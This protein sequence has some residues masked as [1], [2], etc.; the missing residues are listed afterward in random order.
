MLDHSAQH[1]LAAPRDYQLV[2]QKAAWPVQP[3][4]GVELVE[5]E[6]VRADGLDVPPLPAGPV[7]KAKLVERTNGARCKQPRG[8]AL[9][10]SR[11]RL[12]GRRCAPHARRARGLRRGGRPVERFGA[13]DDAPAGVRAEQV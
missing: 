2:L 6:H 12:D 3:W 5:R 4:P 1:S 10:Y 11:A 13:G 7:A 8:P 9:G